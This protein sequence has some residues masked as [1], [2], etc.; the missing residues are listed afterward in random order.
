MVV[1]VLAAVL[2]TMLA[3]NGVIFYILRTAVRMT[4]HQ[5]REHF[6][7]SLNVYEGEIEEKQRQS[8]ELDERLGDLKQEAADMEG[9][10]DV[11]K[12]SPFY[13]PQKREGEKL[14]P[15][16]RYVDKDFF[17]DYRKAKDL[18]K[19]LDKEEILKSVQSRLHYNGSLRRYH[20]IEKLLET[21]N[22]NTVYQLETLS[23]EEQLMILDETLAKE[24]QEIFLEYV[25]MLED[26]FRFEILSFMD[27]LRF[28]KSQEDPV[29]Y[30]YTGE[31]DEK[32]EN[33]GEQVQ[34]CYDQ[35]ICE[36]MRLVYQNQVYD[37]SICR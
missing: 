17:D 7:R 9:I 4:E 37:Y 29:L 13:H 23:S 3:M 33:V 32:L 11:L 8:R 12:N 34:V 20:T 16:A 28:Q 10:V 26:P 35:T 19:E 27:W 1:L 15:L 2:L 22:F 21:L 25:R 24:E 36:G 14:V 6:V 18:M 30:V 5:I 31:K